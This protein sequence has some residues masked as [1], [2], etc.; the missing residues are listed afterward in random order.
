MVISKLNKDY[1]TAAWTKVTVHTFVPMPAGPFNN[2][3]A[4]ALQEPDLFQRMTILQEGMQ[5]QLAVSFKGAPDTPATHSMIN[6]ARDEMAYA[7]TTRKLLA[8]STPIEAR[9]PD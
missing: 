5:A 2:A 6:A 4:A 8:W 7:I 9:R 3:L 1:G